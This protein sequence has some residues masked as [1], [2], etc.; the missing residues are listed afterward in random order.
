MKANSLGDIR[1]EADHEMLG[2]SFIETPDYKTLISATD[3]TVVVGR[4]GSGKSALAYGLAK[5]WRQVP[6][7]RVIQLAPQEDQMIGLRPIVRKFG[8]DFNLLRAACRIMWRYALMLELAASASES[9]KFAGAQ[10]ARVLAPHIARWK[11]ASGFSGRLRTVLNNV[12]KD[13][14]TPEEQIGNFSSLLE[15]DRVKEAL[16]QVLPEMKTEFVVLIDKLDEGYQSDDV[17][18]ALAD[19]LILATINVAGWL[20]N[21]KVTLFARDNVARAVAKADPDYSRDIEGQVLRLHWDEQL[22]ISVVCARLRRAF[23][24]GD[25]ESNLK[26]W[27]RCAGQNL[28]GMSGFRQ[29]LRL[30]LYRPRDI[31]ALLNQAFYRAAGQGRDQIMIEDLESTAQEISQTRLDDLHKEY[32]AILPGL[33]VLTASFAGHSPECTSAEAADRLE[34]VAGAPHEDAATQQ[35]FEIVKDFGALVRSLY[36]VGFIGLRDPAS[37]T[38]GYCHDGRSPNQ[39][40]G[41]FDKLLVHPCYWMALGG[42]RH[43]LAET[44]AEEIYDEYEIHIESQTPEIRKAQLGQHISALDQ[45]PLGVD[46]A[47]R[48]EEWCLKAARILFAGQLSNFSLQPNKDAV[49]RRDIVATN[50]ATGGAWRRLYED[51]HCRQVVM[52]VKNQEGLG[53]DEYRQMLSYLTGE[54]GKCGFI[55]TRDKYIELGKDKEL[56]WVKEIYDK[57]NGVLIVKLTGTF[58]ASLLSKLRNPQRHDEANVRL[59][60]LF[61]TYTRLYLAGRVPT[62]KSEGRRRRPRRN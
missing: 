31:L 36:S 34:A 43:V 27:N 25:I 55:I 15:V 4:R 32:N 14:V 35:H 10:A 11:R 26:V 60:K 3:R 38:F 61:D 44:E 18:T 29:C 19:G 53:G 46:G 42:P 40:F 45:M 48:F 13:G 7:T 58:I 56:N 59:N 50:I 52:E 51:Y 6:K 39:Q 57:H 49:Q 17:G 9:Y 37:G 54:Y 47:R 5:H 24:L 1:A 12:L 8:T 30:T 23:S 21:T 22:L 33:S 28:R 16:K 2:L 41:A 20:P 62:P